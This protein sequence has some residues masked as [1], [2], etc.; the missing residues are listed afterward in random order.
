MITDIFGVITQAITSFGQA[1]SSAVTAIT[2]MFYTAP[3]GSA[4]SGEFT[5]LGYLMLISA[6]VAIVY[7]AFYLIRGALHVGVK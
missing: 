1:L 2:G 7:W 3:T 6:G 4:T 5:F